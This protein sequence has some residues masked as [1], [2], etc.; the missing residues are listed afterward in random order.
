MWG[1]FVVFLFILNIINVLEQRQGVVFLSKSVSAHCVQSLCEH[2]MLLAVALSET[3]CP[4]N[5][6]QPVFECQ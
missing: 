5:P 3:S 2:M 4:A 1:F 6:A